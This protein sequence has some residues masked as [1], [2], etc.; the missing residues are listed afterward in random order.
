ME[1]M[2]TEANGGKIDEPFASDRHAIA[3]KSFFDLTVRTFPVSVSSFETHTH[4]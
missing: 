1:G 2:W 3:A 4:G